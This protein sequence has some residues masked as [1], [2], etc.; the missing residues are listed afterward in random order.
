VKRIGVLTSGG[1]APGM[2]ANI[3][4]VVRA[5]LAAGLE[6]FGI[7]R[8]YSGLLAGVLRPFASHDVSG[9]VNRG[10]T[11]LRSARCAEFHSAEGRARAAQVCALH[12][13]EGL[14]TCGGDGTFTGARLLW[15]EH[16]IAIAGTPGTIDN[17]LAGTDHTIG[18]DTA[19]ATAV[20]ACDK[21]RDTAD[22]HDRIF[23]V[24]VM[25]RRR[26]DIAL[27]TALAAGAEVVLLPECP[28]FDLAAGVARLRLAKE[29]GKTSM[30]VIVAE[31]A[32][33][34]GSVAQA[35]AA[36]LP[37]A[38]VRVSVLGHMLRG[39]TPTANDRLLATITGAEAVRALTELGRD[40]CHHLGV[41][42]NQPVRTP[43]DAVIGATKPLEPGLLETLEVTAGLRP[44]QDG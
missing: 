17:D 19:V 18:F 29:A 32:G 37:G 27:H 20:E 2:N 44:G 42:A 31:G 4:A 34:A 11:I 5:G 28:A 6:V 12:G 39:G 35:I 1:D 13:I 16:G 9:I 30:L 25:G 23:V 3:R 26:G 7:E 36:G 41:V 10:G 15:R 14:V 22:S 40:C 8:G 33:Q 43:L 38:S 24:E 21:I